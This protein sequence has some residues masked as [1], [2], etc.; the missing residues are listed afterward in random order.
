MKKRI[1]G[2][3]T[4]LGVLLGPV[5]TAAVASLPP[6]API[7]FSKDVVELS[8]AACTSNPTGAVAR[9]QVV[10]LK[11]RQGRVRIQLYNGTA[12]DFLVKG[13]WLVRMQG[14]VPR[15]GPLIVCLPLQSVGRP[16]GIVV[17]HDS[18][19]NAKSDLGEDGFGV[20]NNPKLGLSKPKATNAAFV[21]QA[22][23][24]DLK[25]VVNYLSGLSMKPVK[26][27]VE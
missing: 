14:D 10:G 2:F 17:R 9:I 12:D 3:V 8:Q 24:I 20:S 11:N 18:N 7:Q 4:I 15:S 5:A 26:N 22:G 16:Y 27:P 23:V 1:L 19:A 6:V 25:I 13:R 21:A